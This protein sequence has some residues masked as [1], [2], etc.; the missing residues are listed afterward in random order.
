MTE[1]EPS[2]LPEVSRALHNIIGSWVLSDREFESFL[3][4]P[5]S[6]LQSSQYKPDDIES[7]CLLS[8][9]EHVKK[10]FPKE[11]KTKRLSELAIDVLDCIWQEKY[12]MTSGY[13]HAIVE[14]W[15]QSLKGRED[16]KHNP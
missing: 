10:I 16:E 15:L 12:K 8:A 4:D 5:Q 7:R 9:V 3:A 6:Y 2:R 1:L 14:A 11:D 13:S